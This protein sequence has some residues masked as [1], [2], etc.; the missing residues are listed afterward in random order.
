[1]RKLVLLLVCIAVF[2][3]DMQTPVKLK[4]FIENNIG[5]DN[6]FKGK[7]EA[8][9]EIIVKKSKEWSYY[10][11]DL[12]KSIE[13]STDVP[14]SQKHPTQNLRLNGQSYTLTIYFETVQNQLTGSKKSVIVYIFK[15]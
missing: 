1:M 4:M 14:F 15:K 3:G 2:A 5:I 8:Q 6:F 7:N 10:T 13:M 9:Q 12:Y 11:F